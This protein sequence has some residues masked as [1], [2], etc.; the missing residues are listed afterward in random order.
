MDRRNEH[1]CARADE[2]IFDFS[3]A[4]INR[5][6]H[7]RDVTRSTVF[8]TNFRRHA[9]QSRGSRAIHIY[10]TIRYE[11]ESPSSFARVGAASQ[12]LRYV[13]VI[14]DVKVFPLIDLV[15]WWKRR[16]AYAFWENGMFF[17]ARDVDLRH[18]TVRRFDLTQRAAPLSTYNNI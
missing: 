7:V 1:A 17:C 16:Y 5:V 18:S 11:G 2:N 14:N 13:P 15:R 4:P 12:G 10:V 8:A 3:L 6:G 9:G